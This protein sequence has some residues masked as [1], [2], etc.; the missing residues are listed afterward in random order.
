MVAAP[1]HEKPM[2]ILQA[3][4]KDRRV[5]AEETKAALDAKVNRTPWRRVFMTADA[6]DQT[7]H[8]LPC[9]YPPTHESE[10]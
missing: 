6:A 1:E 7:A 4:R 3:V 8:S 2:L 9:L 5:I 10:R